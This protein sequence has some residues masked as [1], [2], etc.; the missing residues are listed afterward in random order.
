[1]SFLSAD[2]DWQ[3]TRPDKHLRIKHKLDKSDEIADLCA[4]AIVCSD[5]EA[6]HIEGEISAETLSRAYMEWLG[7]AEGGT[8]KDDG[9]SSPKKKSTQQTLKKKK[10][11]VKKMLTMSCGESFRLK[12]LSLIRFFGRASSQGGIIDKLK[13]LGTWGTVKNYVQTLGHFVKFLQANE[14]YLTGWGTPHVMNHLTV[15][16]AGVLKSV[17]KKKREEESM[18]KGGSEADLIPIHIITE[19]LDSQIVKDVMRMIATVG[20]VVS[21]DSYLKMRNHLLLILTLTNGKRSG[22]FSML[23]IDTVK[24][25]HKKNQMGFCL[26]KE[27]KTAGAYGPAIIVLHPSMFAALQQFINV[28][29]KNMGGRQVYVFAQEDGSHM[30]S[31]VINKALQKAWKEWKDDAPKLTATRIRKSIVTFS[32]NEG[33]LTEE[34][35]KELSTFMDHRYETAQKYYNLSNGLRVSQ[36]ACRIITTMFH[37]QVPTEDER[38]GDSGSDQEEQSG[39]EEGSDDKEE[40]SDDAVSQ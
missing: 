20:P 39:A 22:V 38:S 11:T 26:V 5:D 15:V 4:L 16:Y 18:K 1:M 13:V 6:P 3:G 21:K 34:Q 14:E 35:N 33:Y 17:S 23:T 37:V 27:H 24:K 7:S 8:P 9:Y 40:G 36:R 28:V 10:M 12:A 29:R 2:C 25:A 19:Y 30:D 32:R 31:S